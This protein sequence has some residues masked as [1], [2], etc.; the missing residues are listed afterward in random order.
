MLF[1]AMRASPP[2]NR[3]VQQAGADD[4]IRPWA[5][6]VLQSP[7]NDGENVGTDAS[8]ARKKPVQEFSCTGRYY[9]FMKPPVFMVAPLKV[10]REEGMEMLYHLPL[11]LAVH[12]NR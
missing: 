3:F 1:G 10:P 4:H 11:I 9:C 12:I 6:R 8:A 5:P 7:H 2:T